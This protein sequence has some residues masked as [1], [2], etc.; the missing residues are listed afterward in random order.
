MKKTY[1]FWVI[2]LIISLSAMTAI[3]VE[4]SIFGGSNDALDQ[5]ILALQQQL[6]RSQNQRDSLNSMLAMHQDTLQMLI[7]QEN[8]LVNNLDRL[9]LQLDRQN[10]IIHNLRTQSPDHDIATDSL[11]NDLNSIARSLHAGTS[12]N[13]TN[14]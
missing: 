6:E 4:R 12:T 7:T 9:R 2:L 10:S 13:D 14:G 11:L 3:A 1:P 8:G 5:K